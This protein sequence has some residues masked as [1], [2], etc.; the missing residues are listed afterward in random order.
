MRNHS[1]R[2]GYQNNL[3]LHGKEWDFQ[4]N[5]QN[6]LRRTHIPLKT[7]H[8]LKLKVSGVLFTF[9]FQYLQL[10]LSLL[11]SYFVSSSVDL[12]DYI[13]VLKLIRSEDQI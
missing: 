2:I 3:V 12:L 11:L 7:S 9:F 10:S 1:G 13:N 8:Q 5:L 6:Q 4:Q